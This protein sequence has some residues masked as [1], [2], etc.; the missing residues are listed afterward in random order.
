LDRRR[1]PVQYLQADR[2]RIEYE[3]EGDRLILSLN[4]AMSVSKNTADPK[5]LNKIQHGLKAGLTHVE[6]PLTEL[7]ADSAKLRPS[8]LDTGELKTRL[9]DADSGLTS[10]QKRMIKTEINKRYSFSLA[11]FTFALIGIPL[12]VTAQ[13]RETS[14]GFAFSMVIAVVYFLFIIIADTMKDKPAAQYLMWLPNVV[15]VGFGVWLF[16]R[17]SKR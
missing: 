5:N 17:L 11:C 1:N 7:R 4:D 16:V 6:I 8:T 2:A 14:V 15:F 13:R 3:E 12:G 10:A 9:G